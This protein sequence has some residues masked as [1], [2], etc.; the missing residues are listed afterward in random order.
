MTFMNRSCFKSEKA[1]PCTNKNIH[2]KIIKKSTIPSRARQT[3]VRSVT[4]LPSTEYRRLMIKWLLPD[5]NRLKRLV[6]SG[7]AKSAGVVSSN[8]TKMRRSV[9][10]CSCFHGPMTKSGIA[11]GYGCERN[12]LFDKSRIA[13]R[14]SHFRTSVV[15]LKRQKTHLDIFAATIIFPSDVF[16]AHDM[17]MTSVFFRCHL[18]GMRTVMPLGMSSPILIWTRILI[19]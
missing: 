7:S 12:D 11:L 9:S 19:N 2:Y 3:A 1:P 10:S 15:E 14:P 13:P 8:Q 6:P 16:M 4:P 5:T 17:T 18:T